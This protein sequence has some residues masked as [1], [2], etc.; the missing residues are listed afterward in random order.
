MGWIS[1]RLIHSYLNHRNQRVR[2]YSSYSLWPE[3]ISRVPQGSI[4]GPLLFNI[5]LADLFLIKKDA[6]IANYSVTSIIRTSI[7]RTFYNS[8]RLYRSLQNWYP[9]KLNS[10]IRTFHNSNH[11]IRSTGGSIYRGSTIYRMI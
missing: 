10:I 3:I 6:N 2:V 8:N 11:F 1:L 5:Y 9:N 4:P 7:I